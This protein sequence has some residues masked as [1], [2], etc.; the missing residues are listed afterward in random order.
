MK[1]A[2]EC[3]EIGVKYINPSSYNNMGLVYNEEK[4]YLDEE[5][6]FQYFE[7]AVEL[8]HTYAMYNLG[9]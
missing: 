9:W 1:K 7:K 3:Y 2:V 6:S 8:G 4:D 5:K